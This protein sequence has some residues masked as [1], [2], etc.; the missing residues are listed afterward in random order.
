[1]SSPLFAAGHAS[2]PA[3]ASQSP[4][5]GNALRAALTRLDQT[6]V[7]PDDSTP[8]KVQ[9]D[10]DDDASNDSEAT[11]AV[12]DFM[13]ALASSA[14]IVS[15]SDPDGGALAHASVQALL[16]ALRRAA[17]Y[18]TPMP[19]TV[20]AA[21]DETQRILFAE[22]LHHFG[23]AALA[24]SEAARLVSASAGTSV[25]TSSSLVVH[26]T[27]PPSAVIV[28]LWKSSHA[29]RDLC[30]N[31][32]AQF[33]K[34]GVA[35][36]LASVRARAAFLAA[37]APAVSAVPLPLAVTESAAAAAADLPGSD[38]FPS[39]PPMMRS[40]SLQRQNSYA[41][42]AGGMT[43]GMMTPSLTRSSSVQSSAN[44]TPFGASAG[45]DASSAW[46]SVQPQQSVG[47]RCWARVRALL[48]T[49]VQSARAVG[50]LR[51]LFW[52]AR[53]REQRS[54][55][56]A[57]QLIETIVAFLT[58]DDISVWSMNTFTLLPCRAHF[59]F[60]IFETPIPFA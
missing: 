31:R 19:G 33:G 27:A 55:G 36:L 41:S 40:L 26:S 34:T 1:M 42:G 8:E 9:R 2:A 16:D 18:R 54:K 4:A 56:R 23:R 13:R 12:R 43:P 47:Q 28:E 7:A 29:A 6:A 15:A 49:I 24:H 10:E 21:A 44:S 5:T 38:Q 53:R 51:R 60:C 22:L 39:A 59:N 3:A 14:G 58:N 17:P 35:A 57:A 48:K 25:S 11:P 32:N 37:F 30:S 52:N 45:A 20:V 50:T 46:A